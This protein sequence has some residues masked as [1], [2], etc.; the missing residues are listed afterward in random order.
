MLRLMDKNIRAWLAELVGTYLVV[1]AG[2]G[3]L[4]TTFL[5]SDPRYA[6]VGGVVLAVALAE[7]FALAVAVSMTMHLSAGCCNPAITLALWVTRRLEGKQ[8]LLL[9]GIQLLA[10]RGR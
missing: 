3:T 7:G 5:V 6:S 9:G 10:R 8:A 4:C 2:A 1:L